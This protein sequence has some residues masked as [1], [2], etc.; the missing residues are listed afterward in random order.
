MRHTRLLYLASC[1]VC[2]L[3]TYVALY[4]LV[5]YVFVFLPYF[6]L[7]FISV[8]PRMVGCER[9]SIHGVCS[10]GP[11]PT[12]NTTGKWLLEVSEYE[13]YEPYE[14]CGQVID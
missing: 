9:S 10:S 8:L 12:Q 7:L 5:F 1:S 2:F 13:Q 3:F 11:T 14:P 6:N 4:H